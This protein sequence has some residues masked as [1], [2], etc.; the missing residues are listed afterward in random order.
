MCFSPLQRK[1]SE[2]VGPSTAGLD[3]RELLVPISRLSGFHKCG[4]ATAIVSSRADASRLEKQN[5]MS[6]KKSFFLSNK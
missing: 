5:F 1:I 2:L 6:Q 4:R 3:L